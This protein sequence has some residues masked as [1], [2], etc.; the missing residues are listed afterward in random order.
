MDAVELAGPN[1]HVSSRE[2]LHG[3]EQLQTN[4]ATISTKA[5]TA[6]VTLAVNHNWIPKGSKSLKQEKQTKTIRVSQI[7]GKKAII[8]SPR[9]YLSSS[10]EPKTGEIH[11]STCSSRGQ[12]QW[13]RTIGWMSWVRRIHED[14]QVSTPKPCPPLGCRAVY[15]AMGKEKGAR[16]DV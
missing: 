6:A 12:R 1:S 2:S 11:G 7:K 5:C 10:L 4:T 3:Q 15:H 14:H 9:F 8:V 16:E 13:N